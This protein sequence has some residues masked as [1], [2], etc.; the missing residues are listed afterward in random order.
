MEQSLG[1]DTYLPSRYDDPSANLWSSYL[2][3]SQQWD[4]RLVENWKG[5]M[6]SILIFAGL[7]SA[8][9]TAFIIESYQ[10]LNPNPQDTMVDLL[11]E[12]LSAQVAISQNRS[13][14]ASL[15]TGN[16]SVPTSA[17]I[18]NT[19]WFLSL[20]FSLVCALS[21][22]LVEQW[23]RQY[24]HAANGRPAPQDRA[25]LSAYLFSGIK[26][27]KMTTLVE[28]IPLLLH[29]SLFLFFAGLVAFLSNVNHFLQYL[30]LSV[31]VI[32]CLL[33]FVIS[34]IPIVQLECPYQ[35]PLS[36]LFWYLLAK[37]NLLRRKDADGFTVLVKGPMSTAREMQA[38]DPTPERDMRDLKAMEWTLSNLREDTEL[39]AFV[40]VIP[41]VVSGFDY[42][43]K[44]LMDKLLTHQDISIRLPHQIP[45]LLVTCSTGLLEPSVAKARAIT[46]LKAIWSLT[47]LSI[48]KKPRDNSFLDP[49]S[50]R[51]NMK[52]KEDT[53]DLLHN[54]S[55][56]VE[57]IRGFILSTAAVF[58]QSLLDMHTERAQLLENALQ[59]LLDTG[60]TSSIH[61]RN[62]PATTLQTEQLVEPCRL[63]IQGLSRIIAARYT[64]ITALPFVIM[65]SIASHQ[66]RV[67]SIIKHDS[68]AGKLDRQLVRQ[69]LDMVQEFQQ[70]VN[71]AAFHLALFYIERIFQEEDP[72]HEASNTLRRILFR[73]NFN[74]TFTKSSQERLVAYLDE[75]ID[76][77]P[78]GTTR[79]PEAI[80]SNIINFTRFL[81]DEFLVAKAQ[82]IIK[83]YIKTVHTQDDTASRALHKLQIIAP[84]VD[85][86]HQQPLDL[87]AYHLSADAK[88]DK[89]KKPKA[90]SITRSWTG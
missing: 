63:R 15:S 8:S 72:P 70:Q 30:M 27:Y 67:L 68:T 44:L 36:S 84:H 61:L 47:M 65:E 31:L 2:S 23:T 49:I 78:G 53:F 11:T 64:M 34:V 85:V 32:S 83:R 33:Y 3:K 10:L 71:H 18:C 24:I 89:E 20:A 29:I 50:F 42:S 62:I 77:M 35:T 5:D 87:F 90:K 22:T 16:F 13:I 37:F 56:A 7:F 76:I 52:F 58:A 86:S 12:L 39:E 60:H 48:P 21:A 26:E 55:Q 43:A 25:R 45:R 75:A 17:I 14:S 81:S 38:T 88:P 59:E 19:L 69:T 79:L 4:K 66:L 41:S 74:H 1:A 28:T 82:G 80:V 57:G 46:C 40:R 6:D 73:I 54:T 51:S 9:L